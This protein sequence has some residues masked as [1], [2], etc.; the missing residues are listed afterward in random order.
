MMWSEHMERYFLIKQLCANTLLATSSSYLF[1]ICP[2]I[3]LLQYIFIYRAYIFYFLGCADISSCRWDK[4]KHLSYNWYFIGIN[5][6]YDDFMVA[7]DTRGRWWRVCHVSYDF[8]FLWRYIFYLFILWL[9][10]IFI[11]RIIFKIIYTRFHYGQN[12][13]QQMPLEV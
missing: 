12:Q 8:Y 10:F 2:Y 4:A 5:D 7:L 11:E 6:A 9:L 3:L 13:C 1:Y